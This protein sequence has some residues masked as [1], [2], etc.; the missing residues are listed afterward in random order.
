MI[1][2]TEKEKATNLINI[3]SLNK[4]PLKSRNKYGKFKRQNI[5]LITMDYLG[6]KYK[7]NTNIFSSI[8]N[9]GSINFNKNV[10]I[11]D[12]K[13]IYSSYN[14]INCNNS[15]TFIK[16][17]NINNDNKKFNSKLINKNQVNSKINCN[18]NKTNFTGSNFIQGNYTNNFNNTFKRNSD[19]KKEINFN[20][21]KLTQNKI[22]KKEGEINNFNNNN[23]KINTNNIINN[24]N[25]LN[26]KSS[27]L[28]KLKEKLLKKK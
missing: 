16:K 5:N 13:K 9:Y 4:I 17:I 3:E 28:N 23:N 14:N 19:C 1:D 25:I 21:L 11:H 10:N 26:D 6:K 27:N 2:L 22:Q 12:N 18:N 8:I 15:N 7:T 24:N 20:N